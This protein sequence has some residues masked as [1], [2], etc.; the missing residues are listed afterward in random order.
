MLDFFFTAIE[1]GDRQ[2]GAA[3]KG[4]EEID[5]LPFSGLPGPFF[6]NSHAQVLITD[7]IV[8]LIN[9]Q[10][11]QTGITALSLSAVLPPLTSRLQSLKERR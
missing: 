2:V 1:V 11:V 4:R 10:K 7:S 3:L 9:S 8:S 6:S 5:I